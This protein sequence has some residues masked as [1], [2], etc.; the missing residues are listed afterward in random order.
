MAK[1][2]KIPN[3]IKLVYNKLM[4]RI[5]RPND[6]G[7]VKSQIESAAD[8]IQ[9]KSALI[10]SP[11]FSAVLERGRLRQQGRGIL[12]KKL[13]ITVGYFCYAPLST[14]DP[15]P[16]LNLHSTIFQMKPNHVHAKSADLKS[17]FTVSQ[18]LNFLQ[19][20]RFRFLLDIN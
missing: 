1:L 16:I 10:F 15:H 11:Q 8:I 17:D 9:F 5:V 3:I 18:I 2:H 6:K 7:T 4:F 20:K 19:L 12:K 13:S 14:F